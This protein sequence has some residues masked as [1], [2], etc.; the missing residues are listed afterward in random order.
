MS[1]HLVDIGE[2]EYAVSLRNEGDE[3]RGVVDGSEIATGE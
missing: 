1:E 3:L 2:E